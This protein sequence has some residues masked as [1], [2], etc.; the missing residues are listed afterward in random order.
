MTKKRN[1]R[2]PTKI[3]NTNRMENEK[4]KINAGIIAMMGI[5]K[6]AIYKLLGQKGPLARL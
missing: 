1:K 5:T 2:R 6:L 3:N 4:F